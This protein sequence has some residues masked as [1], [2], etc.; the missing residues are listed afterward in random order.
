[1]GEFPLAFGIALEGHPGQTVQEGLAGT[2]GPARGGLVEVEAAQGL[3]VDF[4]L[5]ALVGGPA[6]EIRT[7]EGHGNSGIRVNGSTGQRPAAKK[8]ENLLCSP[9]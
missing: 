4:A 1:L 9:D 8:Q 6:L 5:G 7:N 2:C 3:S